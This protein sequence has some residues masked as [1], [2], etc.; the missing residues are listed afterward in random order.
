[1][2]CV[3]LFIYSDCCFNFFKFSFKAS[4]PSQLGDKAL[5]PQE[6]DNMLLMFNYFDADKSG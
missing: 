1:M 3:Y 2:V 4:E 5:T 6:F